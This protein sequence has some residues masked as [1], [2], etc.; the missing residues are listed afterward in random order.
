MTFEIKELTG[1]FFPFGF[2][3]SYIT[4]LL[5]G[6]E[7][8]LKFK[9]TLPYSLECPTNPY[10]PILLRKRRLINTLLINLLSLIVD[11]WVFFL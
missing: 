2:K 9:L 10:H 3:L 1:L 4:S 6:K 7:L 11:L 8:V 5:V